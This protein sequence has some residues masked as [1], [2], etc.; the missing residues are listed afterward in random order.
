MKSS[1]FTGTLNHRRFYPK[2][3]AFTYPVLLFYLDLTEIKNIFSI[4]LLFSDQSPS[5]IRFNRSDYLSGKESLIETVRDLIFQKTGR[6]HQ[7]PIRLLTQV[8]Y[9]GFCFN[10]VSFY[11]CFEEKGENLEFIVT[12]VSNTPWNERKSYV[13]ECEPGATLHRV[14]F[15]KD[16]HISPFLPMDIEHVWSFSSFR[17]IK[18]KTILSVYMEDWNTSHSQLIF[19]ATLTLQSVPLKRPN[20][21]KS[22]FSFPLLT[23]KSF[24]AI[25]YQAL[26][27]KLKGI[28]FYS[29]PKNLH[30]KGEI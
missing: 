15:K 23:F 13:L 25:Y 29:H 4:P 7:G 19:D 16:F 6:T 24:L 10:P 5:I 14:Q 11:Y 22:L 8:R 9:F 27:L 28:P 30:N 1:L 3:H 18:D 12:E 20:L 21:I 26:R 17:K 2:K